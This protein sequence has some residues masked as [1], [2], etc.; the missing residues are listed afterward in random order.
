MECFETLGREACI[1]HSYK[2]SGVGV[3]EI[4]L[5]TFLNHGVCG[6]VMVLMVAAASFH[7]VLNHRGGCSNVYSSE[8]WERRLSPYIE[9]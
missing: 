9:S 2:S 7:W 5:Y 6:V 1:S 4:Q 3:G 8:E